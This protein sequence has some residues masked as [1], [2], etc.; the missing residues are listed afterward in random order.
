MVR[1]ANSYPAIQ[2]RVPEPIAAPTNWRGIDVR[3]LRSCVGSPAKVD[4]AGGDI[5][6][7]QTQPE[8][9]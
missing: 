8:E 6:I 2:S 1:V 5:D 3:K 7:Y 4:F 9:L